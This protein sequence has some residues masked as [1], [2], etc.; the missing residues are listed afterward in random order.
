MSF[1]ELAQKSRQEWLSHVRPEIQELANRGE[2]INLEEWKELRL[3]SW[4]QEELYP[5]LDDEAFIHVF[6]H[7]LDNCG[8]MRQKRPCAVYDEAMRFIFIPEILKR[9]KY[10]KEEAP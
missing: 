8:P 10:L 4:E 2:L 1:K 5:H 7:T 6:Q 3:N 9:F